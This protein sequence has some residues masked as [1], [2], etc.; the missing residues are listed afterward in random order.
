MRWR[1][2][3][4][5]PWI[6]V[7]GQLGHG[8]GTDRRR[9]HSEDAGVGSFWI[10]VPRG[11]LPAGGRS[12]CPPPCWVTETLH[13]GPP[14]DPPRGPPLSPPQGRKNLIPLYSA[15]RR[16]R[17]RPSKR[18]PVTPS[19]QH[20][21]CQP[22]KVSMVTLTTAVGRRVD[23]EQ[24][25]TRAEIARRLGLEGPGQIRRLRRSDA[26]FPAPVRRVGPGERGPLIWYWRRLSGGPEGAEAGV[27]LDVAD[28]SG[29]RRV[30][31]SAAV[32]RRGQCQWLHSRRASSVTWSWEG[33]W[34]SIS[35]WARERSC[36]ASASSGSRSSTTT[37]AATPASPRRSSG[38]PKPGAE[39]TS[40]TGRISSDGPAARAG[41]PS[42]RRSRRRHQLRRNVRVVA[43]QTAA[44]DSMATKAWSPQA[45]QWGRGDSLV[46]PSC[47]CFRMTSQD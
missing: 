26:D 9:A 16:S 24:L 36:A 28:V 35:W 29:P 5:L 1:A 32:P 18:R 4:R 15:A 19:R 3:E 2:T 39:P 25:V 10:G 42:R 30:T 40:G 7:G 44:Y 23:V 13:L 12:W 43:E 20:R 6:A 34:M 41:C 38:W 22:A 45:G 37:G 17:R 21:P 11:P 33:G 46:R 47:A 8:W 14:R 27:G 31:R